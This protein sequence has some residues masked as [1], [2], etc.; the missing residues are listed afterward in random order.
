MKRIKLGEI[1]IS[2][3]RLV[4]VSVEL[5]DKTSEWLDGSRR[6]ACLKRGGRMALVSGRWRTEE[7]FDI[8]NN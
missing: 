5:I 3:M 2:S 4:I 1:L 8:H 6:Q 7:D